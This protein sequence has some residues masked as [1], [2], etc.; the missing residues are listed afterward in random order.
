MGGQVTKMKPKL[1]MEWHRV[2]TVF[3]PTRELYGFM[4]ATLG[5]VRNWR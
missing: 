2:V 3:A 4:V 1:A 5:D